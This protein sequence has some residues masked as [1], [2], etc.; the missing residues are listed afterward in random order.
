MT[1]P[2]EQLAMQE[3][4]SYSTF[5]SGSWSHNPGGWLHALI[6]SFHEILTPNCN[7]SPL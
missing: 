6:S 7:Y 5:N 2:I 1:F 3:R 4:D